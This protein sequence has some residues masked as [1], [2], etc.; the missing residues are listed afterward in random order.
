[1]DKDKCSIIEFTDVQWPSNS[2]SLTFL[3]TVR[4]EFLVDR[5]GERFRE[6]DLKDILKSWLH[7]EF[8]ECPIDFKFRLIA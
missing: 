1:M 8:N 3:K 5:N 4:N 7:D 2:N 6:D